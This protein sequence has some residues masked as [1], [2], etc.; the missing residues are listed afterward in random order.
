MSSATGSKGRRLAGGS[1]K[2]KTKYEDYEDCLK[3]MCMLEIAHKC[4]L[5]P[6]IFSFIG[7]MGVAL[8][9][10]ESGMHFDFDKGRKYGGQ[11]CIIAVFGTFCPLIMGTVFVVLLCGKDIFPEGVS[12]GTALA[13]TSV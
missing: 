6:N 13:P 5:T 12:A 11:A 8:M 3:K 9:I 7:H 10:F 4:S 1:Y 2:G